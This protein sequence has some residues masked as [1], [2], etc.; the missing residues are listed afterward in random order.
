MML[1]VLF[2]LI[3]SMV[4]QNHAFLILQLFHF[5]KHCFVNP[6]VTHTFDDF[7][8]GPTGPKVGYAY[9][10][11]LLQQEVQSRIS[12]GTRYNRTRYRLPGSFLVTSHRT[13]SFF[14]HGAAVDCAKC[15]YLRMCLDFRA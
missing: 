10:C 2:F 4:R 1:V 9:I 6:T 8:G 12:M 13:G 5:L 7:L 15:F 14:Q 3:I 11:G